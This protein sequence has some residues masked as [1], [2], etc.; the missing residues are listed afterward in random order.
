[1]TIGRGL[2]HFY[3]QASDRM[4]YLIK[5]KAMTFKNETLSVFDDYSWQRRGWSHIIQSLVF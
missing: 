5:V 4:S 3:T 1:M 2:F